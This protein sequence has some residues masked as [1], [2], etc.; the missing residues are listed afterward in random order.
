MSSKLIN[1][2]TVFT[3]SL[4][5]FIFWHL[6]KEMLQIRSDGWYV[7]QVNLYGDLV[8]HLALINKFANTTG[9][10]VDSPILSG[11][12]VNY[13]I[14]VDYITS[15]IAQITGVDFALFITTIFGGLLV[16]FIS[17]MFIKTYIKNDKVVLVSLL[18]FFLNGGFGFYYFIQDYATSQKPFFDFIFALPR[19]YTDLKDLGYW[20]IN[21]YLAYFLPQRGFLFA[22]PITLTVL[23]LLYKGSQKTSTKFF[24]IAGVLAGS[25]A[26]VQAHSLFVIFLLCSYFVPITI[27]KTRDVKTILNWIIFAAATCLVSIPLFKS[28]SS[29]SN[30]LEFV[31]FDPGWT[32]QENFIWFWFKN[33]GLFAPIWL[34]STV[35]L[36]KKS[37]LFFLYLPFVGIF[38]IS[39]ILVFQPWEFDNSKLLI[40]WYFATCIVIGY[41]LWDTLF[42]GNYLRKIVG[43]LLVLI[44]TTSGS[45]DIFRTFTK[46]SSYQIF[47]NKDLEVARQVKLLAPSD[48]VFVTASNHNHPIPTLSGRSTVV[49]FHGWVWSHGGDYLNRAEDVTKIY[50]GGQEADSLIKKYKVNYVTVGPQELQEFSVNLSYFQKFAPISLAPDWRIYDVG[51]IWSN[52]DRQN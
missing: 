36:F 45:I 21:S 23:L 13:P 8:Y 48:T 25:L 11:E 20:W 31:R 39:N 52:S 3:Y 46:V 12:K 47:S 33:L 2:T 42:T 15:L 51:S 35:W 24:A 29:I 5:G 10:V 40:Y 16:I 50:L 38:V 14:F 26:L 22:F 34:I 28:I 19:E 43:I 30:P 41:F 49:G 7:G 1:L 32:S 18:L 9:P 44:M 37:K 27:I 6:A 4:F 17:K